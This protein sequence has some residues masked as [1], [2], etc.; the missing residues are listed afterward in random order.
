MQIYKH[1]ECKKKKEKKTESCASPKLLADITIPTRYVITSSR[2]PEVPF[3]LNSML[4]RHRSHNIQKV[5][6]NQQAR[7]DLVSV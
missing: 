5:T 6:H 7:C 1:Y 3:F 2:W 4:S